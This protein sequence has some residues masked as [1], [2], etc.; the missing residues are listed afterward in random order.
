MIDNRTVSDFWT[1]SFIRAPS[2]VDRQTTPF[3]N[4]RVYVHAFLTPIQGDTEILS[5]KSQGCSGDTQFL[6][7]GSSGVLY[8]AEFYNNLGKDPRDPFYKLT[9]ET[10]NIPGTL[11]YSCQMS[12]ISRV[13]TTIVPSETETIT[14][15][16]PVYDLAVGELSS[17]IEKEIRDTEKKVKDTQWIGDIQ[18]IIN[19]A[20]KICGLIGVWRTLVHAYATFSAAWEVLSHMPVTGGYAKFTELQSKK[21]NNYYHTSIIQTAS[22][23]CAYISCDEGLIW[24]KWYKDMVDKSRSTLEWSEKMRFNCRTKT[25]EGSYI[26]KVAESEEKTTYKD[27]KTKES[28]TLVCGATIWPQSPKESIVLSAATGCIPGILYNLEK[29]RQ[30]DCAYLLCLKKEVPNGIPLEACKSQKEYASCKYFYGQVF[31][32]IPFA[33]FF[34]DLS[35]Q[36]KTVVQNPIG[37]IFGVINFQCD[38]VPGNLNSAVCIWG[39]TIP[40]LGKLINLFD[41]FKDTLNWKVNGDVCKEALK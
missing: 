28:S 40:E 26:P 20:N 10:A 21:F 2:F 12:I 33:N 3:I 38:T 35:L 32:L 9:L 13:G 4:H 7:G 1:S 25:A 41:S 34:Q 29:Q 8:N 24:G 22:K 23:Y 31:Q 15:D 36:I 6:N 39:K 16:V 11:H 19:I 17:K 27:P 37:L 30:I 5:L 18:N 14:F